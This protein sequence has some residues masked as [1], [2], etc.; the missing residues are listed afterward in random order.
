MQATTIQHDKY[1]KLVCEKHSLAPCWVT[2]V[3]MPQHTIHS[4]YPKHLGEKFVEHMDSQTTDKP[5]AKGHQGGFLSWRATP[6]K[7]QACTELETRFRPSLFTWVDSSAGPTCSAAKIVW[8]LEAELILSLLGRISTI[9]WLSVQLTHSC[10]L[11][12][13]SLSRVNKAIKLCMKRITR[14]SK[15]MPMSKSMQ[16]NYSTGQ[17]AARSEDFLSITRIRIFMKVRPVSRHACILA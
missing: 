4:V 10:L 15:C 1:I 13:L 9:N 6:K 11:L 2:V 8:T 7:I 14:T 12:V 3:S 17:R 5:I 16:N